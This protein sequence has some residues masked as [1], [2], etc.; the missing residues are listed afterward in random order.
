MD[1]ISHCLKYSPGKIQNIVLSL[2]V[3]IYNEQQI[4]ESIKAFCHYVIFVD[5]LIPN[6]TVKNN[7]TVFLVH[8]ILHTLINLIR[9]NNN[10]DLVLKIATCWFLKKFLGNILPECAELSKK[11]LVLIINILIPIAREETT[12][13]GKALAVLEFLIVDNAV[14][15]SEVI[16]DLDP[17]PEELKFQKICDVYQKLRLEKYIPGLTIKNRNCLWLTCFYSIIVYLSTCLV[18]SHF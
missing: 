2:T 16:Q 13:G 14:I 5:F 6:M 8:N 3:N 1:L 18:L 17:F 4:E 9:K 15:L 12:I 7:M 11:I 10:G